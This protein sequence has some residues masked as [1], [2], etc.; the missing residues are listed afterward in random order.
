MI[1]EDIS[2]VRTCFPL[3]YTVYIRGNMS[4]KGDDTDLN[5]TRLKDIVIERFPV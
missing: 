2:A 3:K 1:G 5:R 4:T